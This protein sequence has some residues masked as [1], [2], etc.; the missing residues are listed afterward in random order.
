MAADRAAQL[1]HPA[2]LVAAP[3]ERLTLPMSKPVI[4]VFDS[5]VGGLSVAAEIAAV[6]P[7][8][9]LAYVCDNGFFPYGTKA[10]AA[11]VERVD[12]VVARAVAAIRPDAVVVACNTASTVALPRLRS[13]LGLPVIGVVPA[14]K[15]AAARSR[16][17]VIGL[18]G[19]AGTVRRVYTQELIDRFA[20]DCTVLRVGSTALVEMAEAL[21]AGEAPAPAAVAHELAPFFEAAVAVPPDTIVLACTHFPLLTTQLQAAAP[22]GT[23]FIDSGRAVAERVRTLL[24]SAGDSA[25][26]AGHRAYFTRDDAALQRRLPAF[27]ARGFTPAAL[28]FENWG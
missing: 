16:R 13:H 17:R 27:A 20:A 7:G 11:L 18:L 12:Q 23:L 19:T 1:H 28:S 6:L 22:A 9:Q 25:P 21:L 24:P 26:A 5:G 10:E 2:E 3:Q 14:V 4:A 8:A 15:P